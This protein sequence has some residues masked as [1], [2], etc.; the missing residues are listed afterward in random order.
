MEEIINKVQQSGLITIDLEEY[1]PKEERIVYDISQNLWQGLVL[2]EKDFRDFVSTNDWSVYKNKFVAITCSADAIVP[3]W[4]FMLISGAVQ[5]YAK[6]IIFG[7]SEEL[8]KAVFSDVI[9]SLDETKFRD[10]RV[11]LKGCSK[12]PVPVSAYVELTNK[13]LPVVKSLMFGE[14]CSTVPIYK[15]KI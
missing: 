13:L 12:L 1:Y 5:P 15:K 7:N 2:K 4:A 14:P 11:V 9:Q 8:E 3:A 6:K 10:A